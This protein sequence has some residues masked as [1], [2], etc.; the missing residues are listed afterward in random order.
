MKKI[1]TIILTLLPFILIT[2]HVF[3][4]DTDYA[5]QL[6]KNGNTT[7]LDKI[8]STINWLIGQDGHVVSQ[9]NVK[10]PNSHVGVLI[11]SK[12]F[13]DG[14]V[15]AHVSASQNKMGGCDV[16]FTHI[17]PSEK[18]CPNLRETTFKDWKFF[19][20]MAGVPIYDDPTSSNISASLLT[21]KSGCIVTK[22]GTLFFEKDEPT[23][24]N[25]N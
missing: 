6:R 22:T 24:K 20:D 5:E 14:S 19:G 7:C 3:A 18:S 10:N 15:M 11:G 21:N 25:K 23:P 13:I 16:V 17:I 12:Q 4:E 1:L 2:P 9:W 8:N